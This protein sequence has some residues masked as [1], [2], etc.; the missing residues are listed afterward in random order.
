MEI[1]DEIS[2]T[3]KESFILFLM[4]IV[5]GISGSYLAGYVLKYA[6][7]WAQFLGFGFFFLFFMIAYRRIRKILWKYKELV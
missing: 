5:L 7:G 3:G 2:L 6:P 1:M 4:A